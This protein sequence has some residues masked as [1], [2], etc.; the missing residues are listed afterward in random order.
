MSKEEN[1]MSDF[2]AM[3]LNADKRVREWKIGVV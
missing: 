2:W 3:I 1:F